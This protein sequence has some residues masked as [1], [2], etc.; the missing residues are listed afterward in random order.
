MSADWK[1]QRDKYLT[2]RVQN[3]IEWY[4]QKS[5]VNKRGFYWCRSLVIFSGALIPLL[6]GYANGAMDW[7]K[8]IAGALGVV[9]TVSEG[10][11]SLKKYRENW[12]IYRLSAERLNRERLLY[13]N[14]ASNDYAPGDEAAFRQFVYRAE[15]I[16]AS[17]NED[18][19]TY[20]EQ[21]D[22]R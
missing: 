5:T 6:V 9:V 8:Y 2:E 3:Q 16:M 7:L 19:K 10:I 15:Q 1:T 22:S 18:W 21:T 20:L 12:N 11:L 13:D 4:N 14:H 17:E